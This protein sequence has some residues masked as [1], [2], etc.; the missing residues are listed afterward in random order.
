MGMRVLVVDDDDE[1][2]AAV[3]RRLRA[4]GYGADSAADVPDAEYAL[5]VNDYDC[6]VLDRV[7][8]SGDGVALLA[9]LRSQGSAVPV[10]FLTARDAVPD[11]LCGFEAGGD[12]YLVKPFSM[13]ELLARVRSLCRRRPLTRPAQ[14]TVGDITLDRARREVRRDGVLLPLTAKEL[15]ILEVLADDTGAVVTRSTIIE[16]CWDEHADPMSNVVDVHMA[17]LRRKLGH[18]SPVRTVWGAGYVFEEPGGTN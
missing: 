16:R 10:L 2:R 17:S 1:L 5:A 7:L 6:V 4:V 12:D 9:R 14:V 11:R 13:E 18:P 8:P 15:C 3:V